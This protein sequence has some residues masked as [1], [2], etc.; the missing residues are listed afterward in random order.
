M[1]LKVFIDVKKTLIAVNEMLEFAGIELSIVNDGKYIGINIDGQRSMS[2][3]NNKDSIDILEKTLRVIYDIHI[4]DCII[5][6]DIDPISII[7]K[8][9]FIVEHDDTKYKLDYSNYADNYTLVYRPLLSDSNNDNISYCWGSSA[10]EMV[11]KFVNEVYNKTG[12]W[13]LKE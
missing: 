6:N 8:L 13:L 1:L 4:T 3:R 11:S 9:P 10:K 5:Y 7:A 12:I 2:I